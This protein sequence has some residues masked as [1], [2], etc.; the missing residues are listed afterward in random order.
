[1]KT[2]FQNIGLKA[3]AATETKTC[4]V[5]KDGPSF[6]LLL[7][8][9]SWLRKFYCTNLLTFEERSLEVLNVIHY[10][11]MEIKEQWSI[12][13]ESWQTFRDGRSKRKNKMLLRMTFVVN[14]QGF[15]RRSNT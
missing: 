14:C 7:T 10:S 12:E 3:I 6:G 1:V 13:L 15:G 4:S 9:Q 11:A 5:W 2:H 8:V